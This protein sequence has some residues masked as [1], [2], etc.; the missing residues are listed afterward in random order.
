M[1]LQKI[2]NSSTVDAIGYDEKKKV[3]RVQYK[4]TATYEY[5]HVLKGEFNSIRSAENIGN[6]IRLAI[7]TCHPAKS[8]RKV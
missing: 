1:E 8:Y 2:K 5:Y 6:Q 7:N 3:M 4:G